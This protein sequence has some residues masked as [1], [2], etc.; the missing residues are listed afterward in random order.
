MT[1]ALRHY[2]HLPSFPFA[3]LARVI[4]RLRV[5]A[6]LTGVDAV[7]QVAEISPRPI[8]VIACGRDAVIG[9]DETER[10]FAAARE[11]KRFWLIEGADHARGWQTAP[12]EYERRVGEFFQEALMTEPALAASDAAF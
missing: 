4:F 11:P 12:E 3:D 9:H 5:G 6:P 7:D 1:R 2:F 8:F 10:V